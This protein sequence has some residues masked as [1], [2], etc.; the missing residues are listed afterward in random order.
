MKRSTR[1]SMMLAAAALH[2]VK[3]TPEGAQFSSDVTR[4]LLRA[5]IAGANWE[6]RRWIRASKQV[7]DARTAAI[8]DLRPTRPEPLLTDEERAALREASK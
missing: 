8:D 2:L 7:L 4:L 3:D 5:F 6:R 1:K